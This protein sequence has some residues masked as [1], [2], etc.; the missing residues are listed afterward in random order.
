MEPELRIVPIRIVGSIVGTAA[1]HTQQCGLQDDAGH[2]QKV[3]G[4][5]LIERRRGIGFPIRLHRLQNLKPFFQ[6]CFASYVI[7]TP[8]IMI[9][10]KSG[11]GG[12]RS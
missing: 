12:R 6:T 7:W 8:L 11:T 9:T 4:F 5:E 10:R 1:F 2:G 3:R